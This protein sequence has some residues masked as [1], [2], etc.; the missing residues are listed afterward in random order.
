MSNKLIVSTVL[1]DLSFGF[2]G[3]NL[4][5]ALEELNQQYEFSPIGDKIGFTSF[6]KSTKEFQAKLSF[7]AQNFLKTYSRDLPELK[8]WHLNGAQSSISRKTNLFTFHE[9]DALTDTEINLAN[10]QNQIFV[11]SEETQQVF[12]NHG[13][14]K[15][16]YVPLGYDS[17][18][19]YKTGKKYLDDNV[20]VW[21][22]NAKYEA[23][24]KSHKQLIECWIKKYANNPKHRLHLFIWNPFFTNEQN[25]AIISSLFA[26]REINNINVFGYV[27]TL[28]ELNEAFNATNICLDA[29]GGE[30]WSLGSFHMIGLGKH[31]LIANCS[32]L[33][34]WANESNAVLLQ[35]NGKK[36]VYDN[37]FFHKGQQFNQG[38]IYSFSDD[39]LIDGF[40]RA[41]KR[42]LADKVNH[43]G[44]KLPEKFTWQKTAKL[45][46]ENMA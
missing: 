16:K 37:I 34:G 8:I 46:L 40:E 20:C 14:E 22:I 1:N 13:V 29:S 11:S 12:I 25:Q 18:H 4:L 23:S 17:K 2:V 7:K 32:G 28:G 19:F 27:R 24:R 44:L 30:G 9:L 31:G 41:E 38:N 21:M 39:A 5:L 42:Y 36:E 45:I 26:G 35:P 43:E 33:K 6:S 3:Y 10:N 15:V